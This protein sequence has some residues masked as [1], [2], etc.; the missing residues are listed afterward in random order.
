M[1]KSIANK[2]L[3]PATLAA[4]F[5]LAQGCNGTHSPDAKQSTST[6]NSTVQIAG[7]LSEAPSAAD[8]SIPP[9]LKRSPQPTAMTS[10]ETAKA[11]AEITAL[12]EKL[13][14]FVANQSGGSAW[15]PPAEVN[16]AIVYAAVDA[17]VEKTGCAADFCRYNITLKNEQAVTSFS[18][19][20]TVDGSILFKYS[21]DTPQ[22]VIAYIFRP[23]AD[24]RY[25]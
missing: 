10:E 13:D 14:T 22:S 24:L 1:N 11:E 19:R 18:E 21:R 2:F 7:A 8:T 20:F 5:L 16:A 23:N 17:K 15:N 12:Y 9:Y 3:L 4:G 6:N 25:L